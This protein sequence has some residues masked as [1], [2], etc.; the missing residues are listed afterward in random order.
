MNASLAHKQATT[1]YLSKNLYLTQL[2]SGAINTGWLQWDFSILSKALLQ[3]HISTETTIAV[4]AS[5]VISSIFVH[6]A[7]TWLHK[8]AYPLP[9]DL[10]KGGSVTLSRA[11]SR[12]QSYSQALAL[13]RITTNL[14]IV[15]FLPQYRLW[16]GFNIVGLGYSYLKNAQI[17]WFKFSKTFDLPASTTQQ[18]Y[19]DGETACQP[20]QLRYDYEFPLYPKMDHEGNC[21]I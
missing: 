19:R 13:T 8:K 15:C 4:L 9:D 18:V 1:S 20:D 16:A 21:Q 6:F 7:A 5:T 14:A 17:Q 11:S 12:S 2:F 3:K 10:N